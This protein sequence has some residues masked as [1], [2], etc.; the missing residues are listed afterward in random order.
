MIGGDVEL[1]DGQRSQLTGLM[2]RLE[3]D[4]HT[5]LDPGVEADRGLI[6]LV[7]DLFDK[8]SDRYPALHAALGAGRPGP[9]GL[10]DVRIID[11]GADRDGR[12]TARGW[13]AAQGGAYL[14]AAM[15]LALDTQSGEVL[16]AGSA[17]Q[18]GGTRAPSATR[19]A[20]AKA[21]GDSVTAL[22]LY[23]AQR[24]PEEPTRFG[25]VMGQ[26]LTN[27]PADMTITV[28][29]PV[30][31]LSNTK[32][33][34]IGLAR[35]GN[36]QDCDYRYQ[37]NTN[38]D[39]PS[40]LV[41]FTGEARLSDKIK[42]DSSGR[43]PE[44]KV[45]TLIYSL[46][47]KGY[48]KCSETLAQLIGQV[49]VPNLSEPT[50]M[51][52]S[53][54]YDQKSQKE[55][56]SI[57]YEWLGQANTT[58][59]AFFY[60]FKVPVEN[61]VQPKTVFTVCSLDWPQASTP[62]CTTVGDLEFWWHCVAAGSAVTLA[63]GSTLPIEQVDSNVRV[64]SGVGG[65]SLAV[66][67]TWHGQHHD[68]GGPLDGICRLVTEGGRELVLTAQHPVITPAG[69]V[70][71]LDLQPGAEVLSASGVDRVRSCEPI[72]HAGC[73]YSLKLAD[74]GDRSTGRGLLPESFLANGIA[75]GD[76][77]S[78]ARYYEAARLDPDYMLA[79]L[80]IDQHVD[81]L[82]ALADIAAGR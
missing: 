74:A 52:W 82:S 8:R 64:R 31:L 67:A 42:C 63:D 15:T 10:D 72:D 39:N 1:T 44:L 26:R 79:R 65:D 27:V 49:T 9:E 50:R 23:H 34:R 66:E 17:T 81:Y 2:A 14:S 7:L 4:Q 16:A 53:Y 60:Q 47:A 55:S 57:H 76:H 73:F 77:D 61:L 69:P 48:V 29:A 38:F 35:V 19:T 80:P 28:T 33:I 45:E 56:K 32:P 78:L 62:F 22:T 5:A 71:A 46:A 59:S 3:L 24:S 75:V 68:Y 21:A 70:M 58:V 12:A 6:E 36:Y 54:P 11:V 25:V 37:E 20:T 18:V 30:K 43:I 13:H 41:P 40:L 51:A